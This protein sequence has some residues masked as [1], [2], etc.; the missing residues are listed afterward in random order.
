MRLLD[1]DTLIQLVEDDEFDEDDDPEEHR[2]DVTQAFDISEADEELHEDEDEDL[3]DTLAIAVR[4]GGGYRV[5]TR[6]STPLEYGEGAAPTQR[7][8]SPTLQILGHADVPGG[9]GH[10]PIDRQYEVRWL[11]GGEAEDFWATRAELL[12]NH[13]VAV[14]QYD[15]AIAESQMNGDEEGG[16]AE[17]SLSEFEPVLD[18]SIAESSTSPGRTRSS[19][20]ESPARFGDQ[21]EVTLWQGDVMADSGGGVGKAEAAGASHDAST[22]P[23]QSPHEKV[24]AA[25]D[26]AFGLVRSGL[27]AE[28][29]ASFS[30][31]SRSRSSSNSGTP[32]GKDESEEPAAFSELGSPPSGSAFR[33]FSAE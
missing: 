5:Y 19:P 1:R 27:V 15:S 2:V 4:S 25:A 10:D 13:S 8:P 16:A 28:R 24:K 32:T 6:V 3:P 12:E 20:P 23:K 29:R 26:A 22:P 7:E 11:E 18:E 21:G 17:A 14:H 30:G 31:G 33:R 9:S